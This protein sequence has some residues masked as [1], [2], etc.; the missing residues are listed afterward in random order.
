MSEDEI[1]HQIQGLKGSPQGVTLAAYWLMMG[2]RYAPMKFTID[3]IRALD[4]N[5]RAIF[6]RISTGIASRNM[7]KLNEATIHQLLQIM[8]SHE[9]G[10]T[11]GVCKLFDQ[12]HRQSN[13]A[14]NQHDM[15]SQLLRSG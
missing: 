3:N 8:V 6:H 4:G 1:L 15:T 7:G 9:S 13:S 12:L 11:C 2:S 14:A 10:A 5:G